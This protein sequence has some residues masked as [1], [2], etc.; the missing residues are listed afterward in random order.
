[1]IPGEPQTRR[2]G[3]RNRITW[4]LGECN[5]SQ[6]SFSPASYSETRVL[7][8]AN[9]SLALKKGL[10]CI[11]FLWA[12]YSHMVQQLKIEKAHSEQ[13]TTLPALA[14]SLK[15]NHCPEVFYAY[16]S[17]RVCACMSVSVCGGGFTPPPSFFTQIQHS[18]LYLFHLAIHLG[19][20]S[21]S[22][23]KKHPSVLWLPSR[24]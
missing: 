20:Y 9:M 4:D 24:T 5:S 21:L 13:Q 15:G 18:S 8:P 10:H 19:S 3:T 17:V 14:S 11:L 7:V 23:Y 12:L 6:C 2:P 1:M 16:V 22:G